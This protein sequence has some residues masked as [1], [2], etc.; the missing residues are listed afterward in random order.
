VAFW[1]ASPLAALL[2]NLGAKAV[3]DVAFIHEADE[4]VQAGLALYLDGE[5]EA[6]EQKYREAL[7]RRSDDVSALYNLGVLLKITGRRQEALQMLRKAAMGPEGT[8]DVARA[9]EQVE[10]LERPKKQL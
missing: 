9:A 10:R 8:P 1:L 4:L 2:V 7:A 5:I 3:L 6:A